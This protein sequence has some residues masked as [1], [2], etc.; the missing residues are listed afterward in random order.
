M[1]SEFEITKKNIKKVSIDYAINY[2]KE[3]SEQLSALFTAETMK[4]LNQY[5]VI[6]NDSL[7]KEETISQAAQ[8]I[9]KQEC[10]ILELR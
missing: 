10:I 7:G 3:K 1:K 9:N 6:R 5:T 4:L 8:I 2:F